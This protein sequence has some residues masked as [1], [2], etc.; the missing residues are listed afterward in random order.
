MKITR[1]QL[2][3]PE[4]RVQQ[5]EELGAKCGLPTRKDVF[6]NAVALFEWCAEQVEQGH[7]ILSVDDKTGRQREIVTPALQSLKKHKR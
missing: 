6:E 4:K 3:L 2:D 1:V 5:I 7:V